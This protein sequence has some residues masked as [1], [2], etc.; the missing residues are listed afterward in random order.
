MGEAEKTSFI[1]LQGKGSHS[2]L[3]PSKQCVPIQGGF[4]EYCSNGSGSRFADKDQDT[5]KARPAFFSSRNQLETS[6]AGIK[7]S[8]DGLLWFW[9][10]VNWDLS[11]MKNT[12]QE[13]CVKGRVLKRGKYQV[14]ICN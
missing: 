9:R 3:M 12:Y 14:W 4:E 8:C 7:W 1:A 6:S 2:R 5:R 10:L 11:G 13:G